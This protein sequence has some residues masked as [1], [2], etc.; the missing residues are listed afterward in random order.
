MMPSVEKVSWLVAGSRQWGRSV[1]LLLFPILFYGLFWRYPVF[2]SFSSSYW[3]PLV[4]LITVLFFAAFLWFT[5]LFL[6]LERGP[7]SD[8]P[9]WVGPGFL[10]MGICLF[11]PLSFWCC[12]SITL[13]EDDLSSSFFSHFF[14]FHF[15]STVKTQNKTKNYIKLNLLF[16]CCSLITPW[17]VW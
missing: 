12:F 10:C 7:G 5:C 1:L 2:F 16:L 9:M 15:F 11:G 17:I 6:Q 13:P 14:H 4:M 8:S 3:W